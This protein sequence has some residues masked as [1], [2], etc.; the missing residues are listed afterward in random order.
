M[1]AQII[2]TGKLSSRKRATKPNGVGLSL[3]LI[4]KEEIILAHVWCFM[5]VFVMMEQRP[6]PYE[7]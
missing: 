4:L 6:W 1:G 3:T 2:T 5:V 7:H